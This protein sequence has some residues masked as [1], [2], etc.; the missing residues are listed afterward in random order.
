MVQALR[1]HDLEP[2]QREK[3]LNLIENETGDLL[4]SDALTL[5]GDG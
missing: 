4:E 3:V 2:E 5:Q 1:R